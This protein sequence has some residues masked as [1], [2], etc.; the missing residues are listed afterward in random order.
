MNTAYLGAAGILGMT[1]GIVHGYLGV[2]RVVAPV[3]GLASTGKRVLY[4]L[5]L[6]SALYWFAAG[7]ALLVG[8]RY[9]APSTQTAVVIVAI[10]MYLAGA[11]G[12][13]WAT[14]GRHIGWVMLTLA[15]GLACLGIQ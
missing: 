1:V 12:N 14:R 2:T 11:A 9:L 6:I 4:A 3:Q 5:M 8:T 13:F 15:A 10:L 7:A